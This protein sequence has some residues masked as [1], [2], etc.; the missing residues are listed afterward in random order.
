MR[1]NDKVRLTFYYYI[2]EE[3]A[4]ILFYEFFHCLRVIIARLSS[5]TSNLRIMQRK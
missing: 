4:D 3:I 1:T 2:G 5:N